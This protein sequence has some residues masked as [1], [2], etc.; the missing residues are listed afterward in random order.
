MYGLRP[1][2]RWGWGWR[3]I[4]ITGHSGLENNTRGSLT[5]PRLTRGTT[6]VWSTSTRAD[7]PTVEVEVEEVEEVE[8]VPAPWSEC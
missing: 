3:A 8:E 5:T 1:G 4:L 2:G 6:V 7:P